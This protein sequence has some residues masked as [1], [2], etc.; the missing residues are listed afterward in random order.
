[1]NDQWKHRPAAVD[2]IPR[3]PDYLYKHML[4]VLVPNGADN[5]RSYLSLVIHVKMLIYLPW[6]RY[7]NEDFDWNLPVFE[8]YTEWW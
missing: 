1:M 7:M 2:H 8:L 5:F 6:F 3:G 4:P